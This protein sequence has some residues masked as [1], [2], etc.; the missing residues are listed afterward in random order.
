MVVT[1]R[2]SVTRLK[3]LDPGI[4]IGKISNEA[5]AAKVDQ[6]RL[7]GFRFQVCGIGDIQSPP[8]EG[9]F[10]NT[11]DMELLLG[12]ETSIREGIRNSPV[13]SRELS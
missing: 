3:C 10:Y 11:W 2:D 8:Q 7:R 12:E 1:E 4:S 13:Y 6:Y 5:R 9:L